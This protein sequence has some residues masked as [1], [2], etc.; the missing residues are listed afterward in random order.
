[1]PAVDI[2]CLPQAPAPGQRSTL[3]KRPPP[4]RPSQRSEWQ[5]GKI[6]WEGS[7]GVSVCWSWTGRSGRQGLCDREGCFL[8]SGPIAEAAC[9]DSTLFTRITK[10]RTPFDLVRDEAQKANLSAVGV[11][12][13]ESRRRSTLKF[14]LV[15][16]KFSVNL[17][18]IKSNFEN[19]AWWDRGGGGSI[20]VLSTCYAPGSTHSKWRAWNLRQ[21]DRR[22]SSSLWIWVVGF[23][24]AS[25]PP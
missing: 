23:L 4:S 25:P 6:W 5:D 19:P 3:P 11:S 21:A 22:S 8:T 13:R 2:R 1:V 18:K 12:A 20:A 17:N 10:T 24:G 7:V 15:R 14:D 9:L 16:F